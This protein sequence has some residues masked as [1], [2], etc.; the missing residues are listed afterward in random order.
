VSEFLVRIRNQLPTDVPAER[1]DELRRAE[2]ARASELRR[3]GT[4]V[5]LWRVPGTR[6]SVGL[7]E[8]GDATEL[9]DALASLPMFPWQEI[10]VE[11]LATHPQEDEPA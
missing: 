4:L 10:T 5:R 9:H 3:D 11:A 6:E 7:F 1:R 8:A 2:R